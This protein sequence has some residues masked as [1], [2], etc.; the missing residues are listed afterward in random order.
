MTTKSDFTP[1]E[2]ESL[3]EAPMT[4][5]IY[6]SAASPSV[7]GSVKEAYSTAKAIAAEAKKPDT[8]ELLRHMLAEFANKETAKQAQPHFSSKDPATMKAESQA[9]L[10][11][12]VQLLHDKATPEEVTEITGWLYEVAENTANASKEGGFLGI[13]AV[14]VSD[15]ERQAL[16]ELAG[17][18]GV[19]ETPA[20]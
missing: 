20:E 11:A 10:N 15:A 1:E 9:N 8:T 18:L 4:V 19:E 6:I 2:W 3:L 5:T 7:F 13:G 14:R 16:S 12:V 17:I